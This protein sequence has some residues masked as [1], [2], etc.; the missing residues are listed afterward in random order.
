MRKSFL[1]TATQ[2]ALCLAAFT[3]AHA[4]GG[5]PDAFAAGLQEPSVPADVWNDSVV[6]TSGSRWFGGADYRLLRTHFSEA[7]SFATLTPTIGPSG[8][9]L[10]IVGHELKFNY[11]SAFA[12]FAGFH[13]SDVE[14]VRFTYTHLDSTGSVGGTAAPGQFIVDPIGNIAVP[15]DTINTSANVRLNVYDLE[16][17]WS[18]NQ[19]AYPAGMTYSGGLRFADIH[20]SFRAQITG[21]GATLSDGVFQVG[22]FGVGPYGSL[23]GRLWVGEART[24]SLFGKAG[25]ALLVAKNHITAEAF[26]SAAS[27]GNALG[28]F[29]AG[30]DSG[31]ILVAPV[32][33]S[34]LGVSW[35]PT[36]W[37]TVSAGYFVQAWTELGISGANFSGARLPAASGGFLPAVQNVFNEADDTSI[38]GF[39][40]L[41]VRVQFFY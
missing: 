18:P 27:P 13:L 36:N 4:Q 9:D 20:Q 31:R 30:Q 12:I 35:I 2:L 32:V 22:F 1:K 38:M 8:P 39:E 37:L 40:G 33:E 29:T 16:Y 41:F 34:E 3:T 19:G 5:P 24:L 28:S 15:G 25:G 14:D 26:T 7:V 6:A 11:Q 23:T 21:G 10:R 17:I